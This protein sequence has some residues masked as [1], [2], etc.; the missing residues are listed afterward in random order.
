MTTYN[1][2]IRNM[3]GMNNTDEKFEE[4]NTQNILFSH[5]Y[6]LL[7][8]NGECRSEKYKFLNS[9]VLENRILNN[10]QK[11]LL[12]YMFCK[13]MKTYNAFSRLA[14]LYKFK[15]AV[16]QIKTDLCMNELREEDKQTII[17]FENKN[18]YLF[19]LYDLIRIIDSSLSNSHNFF[20]QPLEIKNPYNNV[21]FSKSNLYN[22]YFFIQQF[23]TPELFDKYFKCNFDLNIFFKKFE[24]LIVT[25]ILYKFVHTTKKESLIYVVNE[26][27]D[28]F[29]CNYQ[30]NMIEVDPSFPSDLLVDIM[31]PFLEPYLIAKYSFEC[32]QKEYANK[33]WY[34]KMKQFTLFNPQFGEKKEKIVHKYSFEA[35]RVIQVVETEFNMEHKKYSEL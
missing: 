35:N 30:I 11:E 28:D 34:D 26:M 16:F 22:I 23:N 6:Y 32:S 19:S 14:Y 20:A 33:I 17:L 2:I 3:I 5:L 29:N 12:L 24:N 27:I 9:M 25:R 10:S 31:K 4:L 18:K 1:H 7:K 8:S 13:M 21:P 15:K